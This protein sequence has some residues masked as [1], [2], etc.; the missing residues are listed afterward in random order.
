MARITVKNRP[1]SEL[2]VVKEGVDG[3]TR[4]RLSD[5]HFALYE[6]VIDSEG[7]VRP[8]YTPAEGC[9]DLVTNGKGILEEITM[10]LET[11]TYY[12]REKAAQSG[13]KNLSEDLCFTIGEDGTIL[14]ACQ[15]APINFWRQRLLR[16]ILFRLRIF[17]SM[18]LTEQWCLLI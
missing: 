1:V 16:G 9:E 10:N 4:T 2:T 6:Q 15:T 17:T 14:Q 13:Y 5:V 7:H 18:F 12:L 11:G 3:N 8:A